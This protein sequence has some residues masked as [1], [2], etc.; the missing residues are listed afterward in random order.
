VQGAE[1]IDEAKLLLHWL[2][3]PGK[4]HRAASAVGV[5]DLV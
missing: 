2:E 4:P 5:T 3:S 1:C